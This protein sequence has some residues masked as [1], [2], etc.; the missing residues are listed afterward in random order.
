MPVSVL[1]E[2]SL[3]SQAQDILKSVL[4]G[5]NISMEPRKLQGV[6]G[7]QEE[8]VPFQV[9]IWD[10]HSLFNSFTVNIHLF[11]KQF[12]DSVPGTGNLIMN[13]IYVIYSH[14]IKMDHGR[15][16]FNKFKND[17]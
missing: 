5:G 8:R 17:C 4:L 15:P 10:Q 13:K 1:R 6:M 3:C 7:L 9:I 16:T 11:N 12:F 2:K 14:Q